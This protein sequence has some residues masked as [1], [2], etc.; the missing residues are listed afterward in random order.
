M[1]LLLDSILVIAQVG[2]LFNHLW[3]GD[4]SGATA[5]MTAHNHLA[6]LLLSWKSPPHG[7]WEFMIVGKDIFECAERWYVPMLRCIFFEELLDNLGLRNVCQAGRCPI[8]SSI[9]DLFYK[10]S[11]YA[12]NK[13]GGFS[14]LRITKM[15]VSS[16]NKMG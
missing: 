12:S 2:E 14:V 4:L 5:V 15:A 3:K 11:C 6:D 13:I 9:L 8:W 7:V 10:H 1:N 16:W